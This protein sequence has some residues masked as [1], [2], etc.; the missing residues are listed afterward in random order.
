MDRR[1]KEKISHK[2]GSR[3]N[4][5]GVI[6]SGTLFD[7]FIP[8]IKG[9]LQ[10]LRWNCN[11]TFK[12]DW[13][14]YELYCNELPDFRDTLLPNIVISKG[15]ISTSILTKDRII[16]KLDKF[17]DVLLTASNRRAHVEI[18]EGVY[19]SYIGE[20]DELLINSGNMP[21]RIPVCI[22]VIETLIELENHQRKLAVKTFYE[23]PK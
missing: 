14:E 7:R 17:I 22:Q 9:E 19:M 1:Y 4:I 20:T 3:N 11:F 18:A 15:D 13:K 8:D 5:P 12:L 21:T 16:D 6:Q 2:L 10:L 23:F